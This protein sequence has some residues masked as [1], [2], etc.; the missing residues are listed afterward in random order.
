MSRQTAQHALSARSTDPSAS[1]RR[2]AFAIGAATS[3]DANVN[4]APVKND[5]KPSPQR[6]VRSPDVRAST[7]G[8]QPPAGLAMPAHRNGSPASSPPL[9]AENPRTRIK[10]VGSHVK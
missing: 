9:N 3:V 6:A 8:S 4:T 2:I 10:Y 5:A 7:S 1:A